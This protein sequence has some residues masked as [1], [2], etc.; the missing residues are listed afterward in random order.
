[1]IERG[2]Y[3]EFLPIADDYHVLVRTALK[4]KMVKLHKMGYIQY[5]NDNNN[6]FSL[7]RNGEINRL[8]PHHLRPHFYKDF[9]INEEM[10][11]KGAYEN[12]EYCWKHIQI[13]KR[14]PTYEHKY[15]NEIVNANYDKIYCIIGLENA[16]K[17][18]KR[19]KELYKDPRNDFLLLEN[20]TR[21]EDLWEFLE[22]Q[23]LDRMKC[24]SLKES[25]YHELV[26]YF[27]LIYKSLENY[28]IIL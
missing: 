1:L 27:H 22:K 3:C 18:M 9:N 19:L 26:N 8:V 28:E 23:K 24:Y 17:N 7:I 16:I 5:M 12:E 13:W 25:S 10:E 4:T 15:C 21:C 2:N 11:K 6:N 20:K 14:G